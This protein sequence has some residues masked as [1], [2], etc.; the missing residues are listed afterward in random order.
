MRSV[1]KIEL[2]EF[3]AG[4][5]MILSVCDTIVF[6]G[7]LKI[8]F[9]TPAVLIELTYAV[10]SVRETTSLIKFKGT[11]E[12]LGIPLGTFAENIGQIAAC[13]VTI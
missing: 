5:R 12:V 7:L 2:V 4:K 8:F 3:L 9:N 11:L 10:E 13:K 6:L 1:Q